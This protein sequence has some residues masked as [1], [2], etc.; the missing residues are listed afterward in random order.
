MAVKAITGSVFEVTDAA[1]QAHR[2]AIHGIRVPKLDENFGHEAKA[3]L[4]TYVLGKPVMI[5]LRNFTK[6]VDT[7]AEVY[8]DGFNI[9]LE[10]IKN[11]MAWLVPEDIAALSES[12]Q[13]DYLDAAVAAKSGKLG[14]WSGKK[15]VNPLTGEPGDWNAPRSG[16]VVADNFS[17]PQIARPPEVPKKQYP[18]YGKGTDRSVSLDQVPTVES[19]TVPVEVEKPPAKEVS[20]A[21]PSRPKPV[22]PSGRTYIRGPFGGCYYIN[23]NGNKS[24][25][26]RSACN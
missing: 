11:G 23:S 25:V 17:D 18:I 14:I 21:P 24:Y 3:S 8:T 16:I 2:V 1:G 12:E 6:D 13:R 7:I 19:F 9:G 4:S 22:A 10:Q 15:G 5:K 20:S 26:D